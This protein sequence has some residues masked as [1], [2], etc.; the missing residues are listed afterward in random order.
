MC[1]LWQCRYALCTVSAFTH[2]HK[3]QRP[4]SG[5]P[6]SWK[7]PS[8][9]TVLEKLPRSPTHT[10]LKG[11]PPHPRTQLGPV[12]TE[13]LQPPPML[14]AHHL[15]LGMETHTQGIHDSSV[16]FLR[17]SHILQEQSLHVQHADACSGRR[18]CRARTS[19]ASGWPPPCRRR[20]AV[21]PRGPLPGHGQG[22]HGHSRVGLQ[23]WTCPTRCMQVDMPDPLQQ[24]MMDIG[25]YE[26]HRHQWMACQTDCAHLTLT[27]QCRNALLIPP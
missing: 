7:S 1:P 18:T 24:I 16:T 13:P 8:T 6:A 2:T 19:Q 14:A 12:C 21:H 23:R 20:C 15:G 27:P 9:S 4:R 11:R 22:T 26:A 10:L 17:V 25:N 5:T 3:V